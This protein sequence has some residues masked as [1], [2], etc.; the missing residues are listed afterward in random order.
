MQMNALGRSGLVVS[1]LCFGTLTMSPLQRDL[2]PEAGAKLL[3]HAYERGVRFLDTADLYGTYP[4]IRLA[5]KDAPDYVISTKAYCWDRET[6]QAMGRAG[7]AYVTAHCTWENEETTLL[8]L[9]R[10]LA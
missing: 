6:A 8:A 9:Y 2:S 7:R 5:L 3:V 1:R 10:A 4:H